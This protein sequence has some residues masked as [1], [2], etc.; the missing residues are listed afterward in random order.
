MT[1]HRPAWTALLPVGAVLAILLLVAGCMHPAPHGERVTAEPL[2]EPPV[3]ASR[4]ELDELIVRLHEPDTRMQAFA[5]LLAFADPLGYGSTG[6]LD[7]DILHHE[8]YEAARNGPELEATVTAYVSQLDQPETRLR[9][10]QV[11]MHFASYELYAGGSFGYGGTG[12]AQFDALR[13]RAA[14]AV[15]TCADPVTV[16]RSLDSPNRQLQSW[17]VAHFCG[18]G[19]TQPESPN[20]WLQLLPRLERVASQADAGI[21]SLAVERLRDYPDSRLF[22][23]NRT[24]AETSPEVLMRLMHDQVSR[25]EFN[26]RFVARLC[27]L[28][29]HPEPDVRHDALLFVGFNSGRAAVWQFTFDARVFDL[30]LNSTRSPLA[31]ER[32]DAAYAL[33]DIRD[34]DLDR[35]RKAFLRL[36]NDPSSEVRWRVASGLVGH[37]Q[38]EDVKS[39][40]EALLQDD[41]TLVR[42]MTILAVGPENHAEELRVLRKC[43]DRQ[44]AGW[45]AEK[46]EQLG[47]TQVPRKGP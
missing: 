46:L 7:A 43:E 45:A 34:L 4:A 8:A 26:E 1:D 19:L 39:V 20:P 15:H 13:K 41:V 16:G 3:I 12:D 31:Q 18:S 37:L 44:V 33:T 35:S 23:I 38:R 21:R 42:Y 25:D 11:L 9:A 28:L 30:V 6:D 36:A 24:E 2:L 29:S 40:I 22:L 10:M 5:D 32:A 27:S 14:T 47:E 17:G